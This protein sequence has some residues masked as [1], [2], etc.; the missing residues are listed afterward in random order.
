MSQRF[1]AVIQLDAD[2]TGDM[3]VIVDYDVKNGAYI[4]KVNY[5]D[6]HQNFNNVLCDIG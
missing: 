3:I 2:G 6:T 1:F 4:V 5:G